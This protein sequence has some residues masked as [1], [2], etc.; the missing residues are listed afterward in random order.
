M[1]NFT[2]AD[3]KKLREATGAGMMDC[4]KALQE[5][6][7]SH[8]KAI[9]FLRIKGLKSLSKREGRSASNGLVFTHTEPGVGVLLE[10]NCETDFVAKGDKF[11]ELA[12]S[13]LALAVSTKA[14]SAE[15]LLSA[16]AGDG[17]KASEVLDEASA[18]IGEKLVLNRV[19]R[20]EAP[21]VQ[22]YEHRTNPDLPPQIGVLLG[23]SGD[24]GEH[25]HGVAMH[26]AAMAPK[27]LNRD[28]VDEETVAK[29]RQ[30]IEDNARE[31][32][33]PE[34]AII[35]IVEGRVR[36]FFKEVSLIDQAYA[37]EPK[38]SVG[39]ILTE[40]GVE[41]TGFFRFRVGN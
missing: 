20:L 17:K 9:E 36:N 39:E 12:Q 8:E 41:P 23:L 22:A 32:G 11:R 10:L 24:A 5:S 37:K 15:E 21:A 1:A 7:G 18:T 4:K 33:K 29:E 40:A 6:E 26:I 13:F 34:Q 30:I 27:F 35:K 31:E 16:D 14:T 19:G 25:G 38:K 2:A 3:V 28:A